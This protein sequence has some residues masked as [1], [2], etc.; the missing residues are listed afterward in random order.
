MKRGI[1]GQIWVETAIYTLIGLTIIGII[2]SIATPE[3]EKIKERSIISQTIEALNNLD[4]E[5]QKVSQSEGNVKIIDFK[6]T[7]GKL[8]INSKDKKIIYTLENSKLEFSE[9]G[10]EIKQGD[11]TLKTEKVGKRFNIIL[12]LNYNNLDITFDKDNKLKTLHGAPS[13]Y[14][15]K[16]VNVGDNIVGGNIHLDF[17]LV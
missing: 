6:I 9:E 3:I 16:I 7:K 1:L 17:S 8:D 13:P 12:E 10:Q 2:L 5:I 15:L 4:G 11:I 14:K